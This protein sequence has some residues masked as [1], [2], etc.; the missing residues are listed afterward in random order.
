MNLSEKRRLADV[1]RLIR[2]RGITTI[3]IE[4]DMEMVAAVS[5]DIV[6]L[7]FGRDIFAGLPEDA[8]KNS[9]VIEAYLGQEEDA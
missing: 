7:N 1:I 2:S 3:L 5:D 8:R 9:A 6:V 4:H